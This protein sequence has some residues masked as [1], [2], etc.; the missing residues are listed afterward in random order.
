MV[1]AGSR[2]VRPLTPPF[3]LASRSVRGCGP[4]DVRCPLL[5]PQ[6]RHLVMVEIA[7]FDEIAY[8]AARLCDPPRPGVCRFGRWRHL[9]L[10]R[11]LSRRPIKASMLSEHPLRHL[12][13]HQAVGLGLTTPS[14]DDARADPTGLAVDRGDTID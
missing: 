6:G 5:G 2:A 11:Q 1:V 3:P 13:R 9:R 4:V 10:H 12:V 14:L 7:G 8:L